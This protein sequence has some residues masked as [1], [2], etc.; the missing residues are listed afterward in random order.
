MKNYNKLVTKYYK[1]NSTLNTLDFQIVKKEEKSKLR[2]LNRILDSIQSLSS[3]NKFIKE[4]AVPLINNIYSLV[5]GEVNQRKQDNFDL[6]KSLKTKLGGLIGEIDTF[7][8]DTEF[9]GEFNNVYSDLPGFREYIKDRFNAKSI[10]ILKLIKELS[11][12]SNYGYLKNLHQITTIN[13]AKIIEVSESNDGII[14]NQAEKKK[15]QLDDLFNKNIGNNKINLYEKQHHNLAALMN[16]NMRS[17]V[18]IFDVAKNI[19]KFIDKSNVKTQLR[20]NLI[21]SPISDNVVLLDSILAYS[22]QCHNLTMDDLS[23]IFSKKIFLNSGD[24]K[25]EINKYLKLYTDILKN[26]ETTESNI[27]SEQLEREEAQKRADALAKAEQQKAEA[28]AKAEQEKAEALAKAEQEKAEAV[29]RLASRKLLIN[30]IKNTVY[31]II[32]FVLYTI[33]FNEVAYSQWLN[34]IIILALIYFVCHLGLEKKVPSGEAVMFYGIA[35]VAYLILSGVIYL[36]ISKL[37]K[38]ENAFDYCDYILV[39]DYSE[40][41]ASLYVFISTVFSIPCVKFFFTLIKQK[42]IANSNNNNNNI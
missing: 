24:S 13:N 22:G 17:I 30:K 37:F 21:S 29:Q 42:R 4:C 20:N 6:Y 28:L 19:F 14:L 7:N 32:S 23:K 38:L 2:K 8:L 40:L 5:D 27:I 41:I 33:A 34:Q 31:G 1:A 36:I 39:S 11:S 10:L 25:K 12:I 16:S 26:L 3:E 18:L 35:Y 9:L 15:N